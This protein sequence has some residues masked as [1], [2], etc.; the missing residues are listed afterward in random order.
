MNNQDN[1][2]YQIALT[3]IKGVGV[4]LAKTLM[5]TIGDERAIFK[6]SRSSLRKIPRISPQIVDAINSASLMQ[7]AEDELDFVVKN[8]L[9]ALFFMDEDYPQRLTHCVDAPVLLYAKGDTDFNRTKVVSIVGTRNASRYGLQVCE[10]LIEDLAESHPDIQ[11]ASGLAYGV[12]ICAHRAALQNNMSTVA[13]L[14]HG[15]D[16]IYPFVHRQ[17]AIDMI[18]NGAL[19]TEFPSGTNPDRHNFVRRNRV[20][21]GMADAVI[22]VESGIKG[23]SLITAEI[24]NSYFREVF[25]VPGRVTDTYAIG[26]NKL[27]ADNKAILLQDANSL[28]KH[29][30]WEEEKSLSKPIQ[31]ELF[32]N[33]SEDEERVFTALNSGE[34]KQVNML[35]IELDIPVSELFFTLLELEMKDIVL[36]LPGGMYKLA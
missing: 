27:I 33:L 12:D 4:A 30:G 31:K 9:R 3:K 23:G 35:S 19:L 34:T 1:L 18:E 25:A 14:A 5:Q 10:K 20:V 15:L 21:A 2:L 11:I 8:N 29:M 7:S 22:V 32:V 6:E 26:A 36:A 17:T 28:L 16:R 13:V 24:A